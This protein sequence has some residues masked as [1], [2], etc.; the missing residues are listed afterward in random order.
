MSPVVDGANTSSTSSSTGGITID[1]AM[2]ERDSSSSSPYAATGPSTPMSSSNS[3]THRNSIDT[4]SSGHNSYAPR[5]SS[6]DAVVPSAAIRLDRVR[7]G[8]SGLVD[9]RRSVRRD[10]RSSVDATLEGAPRVI[11]DVRT[12]LQ[13]GFGQVRTCILMYSL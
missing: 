3:N 8:R 9:A 6:L 4:I 12:C 5:R 7:I 13:C 1:A 10:V 11:G 2:S